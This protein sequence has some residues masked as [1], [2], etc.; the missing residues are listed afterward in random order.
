MIC[1]KL[2]F[3]KKEMLLAR[4]IVYNLFKSRSYLFSKPLRHR[5]K[6][7]GPDPAYQSCRFLTDD[8][9]RT[10]QKG[11]NA[12]FSFI[13]FNSGDTSESYDF[14]PK[15]YQIII[16][17]QDILKKLAAGGYFP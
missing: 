2:H 8:L 11:R 12:L 6:K 13:T 16:A 17:V 7:V 5:I 9:F 14:S 1:Q 4:C 10:K 3:F 15:A